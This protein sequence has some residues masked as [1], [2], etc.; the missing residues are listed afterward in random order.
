MAHT[1]MVPIDDVD[2][3]FAE[4]CE[5]ATGRSRRELLRDVAVGGGLGGALLFGGFAGRAE[6]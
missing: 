2:G 4:T 5:G 1:D 6:A 3:A